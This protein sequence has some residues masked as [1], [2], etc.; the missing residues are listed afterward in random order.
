MAQR[1]AFPKGVDTDPNYGHCMY[2]TAYNFDNRIQGTVVLFIPGATSGS[3]M[4]FGSRHEYAET[5]LSKILMDSAGAP[6]GV[7]F[8]TAQTM[9]AMFGGGVINPKVEVLYR[10]TDLRTFDFSYIV[11]PTSKEEAEYFKE[12][13]KMLRQY[14]SPTQKDGFSDPRAPYNNTAASGYLNTGGIFLTPSEFTVDF[15]RKDSAGNLVINNNIPM[16]GRCVLEN[17]EVMYNPNGEWSTFKDGHPLSAQ[18][19]MRFREMRVI[20]SKNIEV[21]Y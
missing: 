9:G 14:S 10:D 20:D 21:G 17:I 19:T 2:I 11:A 18:L 4:T 3:N 8:G 5:K 6:I 1:V 12:I 7:G 13:V 15:Y 16:M